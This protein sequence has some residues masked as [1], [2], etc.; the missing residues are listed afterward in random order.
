MIK[1]QSNKHS[2]RNVNSIM[3]RETTIPESANEYIPFIYILVFFF[4]LGILLSFGNKHQNNILT[5][6]Y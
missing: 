3:F 5:I 4:K 1:V 6:L 2:Y